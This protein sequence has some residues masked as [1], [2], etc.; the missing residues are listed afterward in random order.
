[1]VDKTDKRAVIVF[2]PSDSRAKNLLDLESLNS[3]ISAQVQ[4]LVVE[5]DNC[6]KL[7]LS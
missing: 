1:M 4:N 6:L 3:I 5:F 2:G 7:V